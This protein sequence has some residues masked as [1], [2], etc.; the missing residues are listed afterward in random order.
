MSSTVSTVGIDLLGPVRVVVDGRP[1]ELGGPKPRAVV[2]AL[3]LAAG[4][5]VS[6]EELERAVW[7]EDPPPSAGGTLRAYLSRLRA[8]LPDGTILRAGPGWCLAVPRV[9]VD[10]VRVEELLSLAARSDDGERRGLLEDAAALVTGEPLTGLGDLPVVHQHRDR[11]AGLAA[12]V[13]EAL[14]D[15]RLTAGEHREV[16]SP[17]TALVDDHPHREGPVRLLALAL[18]RSGRHGEALAALDAFRVR[19]ADDL[20]LDPSPELAD[21]RQGLV[22]HDPSVL[23]T[24]RGPATEDGPRRPAVPLPLTSFVGREQDVAAVHAALGTSRAVTLVGP[25]GCG[26]TR[27]ALEAL[28]RLGREDLDGPWTVELGHVAEPGR[29]VDT[30]AQVLSVSTAERGDARAV[31]DAVRGRRI[32]L[33]LDNCEHVVAEVAD[34]VAFLLRSC[35]GLQVLSTSRE[36]L[37][38]DGECVLPV[39]PLR[40][41]RPGRPD[42]AEALFAERASSTEPSFVLDG[43]TTG[44][45]SRLVRALDGIPLALELA[46]ARL[47]VMGLDDLVAVL[48]DRF[49]VLEGGSRSALPHQ[50]T[51]ATAVE[52]SYDL[53]D[54]EERRLFTVASF[55]DGPFTLPALRGL[56]EAE[57]SRPVLG[58]LAS[59]TAKSMVQV[60][61]ST[62]AR[63]SRSYRL[64]ETLRVFGRQRT[65]AALAQRLAVRHVELFASDAADAYHG[66]RGPEAKSWLARLDLVQPD[67]RAAL[68]AAVD[69]GDR[70]S[71]LR[72][73][74]GLSMYWFHRGHLQEGLSWAEAVRALPGESD[75]VTE[76][77][78]ALGSAL[79][80]YGRGEASNVD[81]RF[82]SDLGRA[83]ASTDDPSTAAVAAVYAGYFLAAFGDLEQA[84]GHFHHAGELLATGAVE[85]WAATEVL[86]AQGQLLRA[87]GRPAEALAA[88]DAAS[89]AGAACG[90]AWAAGSARYIAAKLRVDQA[91][92]GHALLLI[93][94]TLPSTLDLGIHTSTLALLHVAAA[95]T[96]LL[97]RH[98]EAAA[99]LGTVDAWGERL[100][101]HPSRMDPVDAARHRTLVQ[102][103]LTAEEF[104]EAW[105][106]GRSTTL[107][108][109]ARGVMALAEGAS[110]SGPARR[111]AVRG[112]AP[113]A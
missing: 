103:A 30:V 46:A 107:A 7:G 43:S 20:G 111:R 72:L 9:Q 2:A 8:V 55:F 69:H 21:L 83:A 67:M 102:Q 59:L 100:G 17:A 12:D 52:W 5:P 13:Q 48:D 99:L 108:A 44:T 73:V 109:A 85:P 96:A 62:D 36:A 106:S 90:H 19:L 35:A 49:A 29:V 70:S 74:G 23:R 18:A 51:L 86:F 76:A 15:L 42:E 95:A 104:D 10:A 25:G 56:A 1:V 97:E 37:G 78:A 53:L 75:E 64:L 77:R 110:A 66:L 65:E 6:G 54:E 89:S 93:A 33:V 92:G 31:A 4:R 27:L 61:R 38:I 60:D 113:P 94:Q 34:L 105:R 11:L 3:A 16:V 80:A 63:A 91:Q 40:C 32:L 81:S 24:T 112:S 82:L 57:V 88:L 28:R 50:R 26:K 45:V 39:Q 71:A 68:R 79:L 87:Q 47:A 101:Y 14:L 98:V 41:G 22:V 84:G 58:V